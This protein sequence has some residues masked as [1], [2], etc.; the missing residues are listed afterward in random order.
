MKND[1]SLREDLVSLLTEANA[2]A[3]FGDA[4]KDLPANLRGKR[5]AGLPHSPWELVEHLRITQWDI[6]EYALNPKHESPEFPSGYWPKSPEPPDDKA[7]DRSV[8]AFR[9]D[10]S[11]L[12][13]EIQDPKTDVLAPIAHAKNQSLHNKTLLLADHTAY[14]IGQLVLTRRLLG[15]WQG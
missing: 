12:I 3:S 2:H 7:W 5:P 9:K 14:H 11:H 8:A 1:K 15:A 13:E 6:I 10:L 4:V